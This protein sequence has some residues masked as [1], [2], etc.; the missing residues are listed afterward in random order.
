MLPVD[1]AGILAQFG[2]R[3]R[4]SPPTS[5]LPP[6]PCPSWSPAPTSL[7]KTPT[8][9]LPSQS[10]SV[11]RPAPPR[12]PDAAVSAQSVGHPPR[13]PRP[14]DPIQKVVFGVSMHHEGPGHGFEVQVRSH[15]TDPHPPPKTVKAK[16]TKTNT[17]AQ[18]RPQ[19]ATPGAAHRFHPAQR[20]HHTVADKVKDADTSHVVPMNFTAPVNYRPK[21]MK[22]MIAGNE[23]EK[24]IKVVMQPSDVAVST[25][26]LS[27]KARPL[28]P[29]GGA[30]RQGFRAAKAAE[31]KAEKIS[32]YQKI[33]EANRIIQETATRET[34]K[35]Y[36]I[37][38]LNK[39]GT[40]YRCLRK[41]RATRKAF[42]LLNREVYRKRE[43]VK[44]ALRRYIRRWRSYRLVRLISSKQL[45]EQRWER[46]LA[47]TWG[48]RWI[49]LTIRLPQF[50]LQYEEQRQMCLQRQRHA[51]HAALIQRWF[52]MLR[53]KVFYGLL[54]TLRKKNCAKRI[55][56]WFRWAVY[57]TKVV[58]QRLRWHRRQFQE[59]ACRIQRVF[60][61]HL[62]RQRA[63]YVRLRKKYNGRFVL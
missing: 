29:P 13:S 39:I 59:G 48:L 55:Q 51:F 50:K 8:P 26:S 61:G 16:A 63:S 37:L 22:W 34:E 41:S 58:P 7:G 60:R 15:S 32:S 56:R 28:V 14:P 49:Y 1:S 3:P 31:E 9:T 44:K 27:L 23:T 57:L 40:W 17:T 12:A 24:P 2:I 19:T 21:V 52:R 30:A 45:E 43:I 54:L 11:R 20:S 62:G 33:R 42:A 36:V 5:T 4:D 46:R 25:E 6:S 53:H 10:P 35:K 38:M 18:P 47:L